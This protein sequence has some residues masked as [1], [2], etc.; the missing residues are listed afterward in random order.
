[1]IELPIDSLKKLILCI[2]LDYSPFVLNLNNSFKQLGK[3]ICIDKVRYLAYSLYICLVCRE[4]NS[5]YYTCCYLYIYDIL[6]TFITI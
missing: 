3:F 2:S 1:M 4:Y 5:V 6:F